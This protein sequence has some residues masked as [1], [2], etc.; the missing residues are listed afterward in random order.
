MSAIEYSN[1][2]CTHVP[3]PLPGSVNYDP[4]IDFPC[5]FDYECQLCNNSGCT[6]HYC[7]YQIHG[8]C[9]LC[10]HY[11]CKKHIGVEDHLLICAKCNMVHPGGL[12]FMEN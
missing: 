12:L 8:Q 11:V 10:G 7:Q 3:V 5:E 6:L 2:L 1:V 4:D 9:A